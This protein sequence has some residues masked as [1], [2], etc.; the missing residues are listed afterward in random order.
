LGTLTAL[1]MGMLVWPASK[2]R[3]KRS[4]RA[5]L[6]SCLIGLAFDLFGLRLNSTKKRV[7]S[8][9]TSVLN[10]LAFKTLCRQEPNGILGVKFSVDTLH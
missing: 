1:M 8:P 7:E 2:K 4:H 5:A 6:Q 10:K 3:L 9:Q